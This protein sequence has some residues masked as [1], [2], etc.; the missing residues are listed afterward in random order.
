VI[1][2][3]DTTT[4]AGLD[5]QFLDLTLTVERVRGQIVQQARLGAVTS[6]V[7]DG[8]QQIAEV[9]PKLHRQIQALDEERK[10]LRALGQIGAVVNSSLELD[11]VLQIVMDT[12][13]RLTKAERGFLML[14]NEKRELVMHVARNWEQESVDPSEFAVSRTIIYRVANEGQPLLT[15]NAQE[16]PR[17]TGQQSIVALNLRSILCVPLMLRNTVT[18]V[19]YA[20]NRIRS[21]IFTQKD[22]D[23]LTGFGN[24]AS[25]ALENARLYS[26]IRKTLAEVT[27]LKNLM[28]NVFSSIASGVLTADIDQRILLCNRAAESILGLNA[29]TLVGRSLGESMSELGPALAPYFSR[30][31]NQDQQVLGLEISS[32]L[33]ERGRLDLRLSL[34]PLKD[35]IQSTQ[36]VAIV[37]EDLTE[38]RRLEGM[39]RLFERMVSPA[40][41]QQLDPNSLPL[42]GRREEITILFADI[43]GFTSFSERVAPEE[44]V[45]VLNCY[46]A[47]AAE[48]VL[49]EEGTVDKFLGDAVMAW[50]NAPIPQP[51]H[52]LRAVR[53]ALAIRAVLPRLH[54]ALPEGFRLSFGVG[55]HTGD[56]VLGLVGTEKRLEYTAIGDSVNTAK[57][58]QENA[59]A[60][61]ILITEAA[62][63]HVKDQ[64]IVELAE[65]IIAKGKREPINVYQVVGLK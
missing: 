8:I 47:A 63:Q 60:G 61:Q 7:V 30:V 35:A 26:S 11:T 36:G 57:R 15:T 50:F 27:Q 55:I 5:K 48:A 42:G 62:F 51:D 45:A 56:A 6:G 13:I 53:V 4:F 19:I 43:R 38:K 40:V 65:P 9:M 28:D 16:D 49:N 17:F 46:L 52:T 31:L 44:L 24:Q 2:P 37:M 18:G 32:N 41:I 21:G 3:A 34:S 14:Y 29:Q 33:P 58:V 54:Q 10:S 25:V 39:R 12:I 1:N 64:L 22:L 20:D 23:L 59:A